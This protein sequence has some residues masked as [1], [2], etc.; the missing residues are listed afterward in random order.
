VRLNLTLPTPAGDLIVLDRVLVVTFDGAGHLNT[1][2]SDLVPLA[3]A[4]VGGIGQAE[5][6]QIAS[7]A[8]FAGRE[9]QA[10]NAGSARLA[11]VATLQS[12]QV[13]WAVDVVAARAIERYAV[14][15]D[16]QTGAVLSKRPVAIH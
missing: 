13:V 12:T 16:S 9:S 7:K 4:Q 1:V 11:V 14:L 6:R 8:I 5:A 3:P 2:A 15:V 10:L